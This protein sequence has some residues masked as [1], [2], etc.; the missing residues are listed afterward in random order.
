MPYIPSRERRKEDVAEAID[1]ARDADL[2][3]MAVMNRY[4]VEMAK[5]VT[6]ALPYLPVA[7][8]SL[9]SPYYITSV[10]D[11]DAYVCTYSYLDDAQTAA[12]NAV[13]GR[14]PMLGKLPVTIPG[15]YPYGYRVPEPG[16]PT[17]AVAASVR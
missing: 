2:L 7:I 4:H 14:A 17:P 15:M 13:L 9:A 11:I 6:K 16:E 8:V 1:I 3:V 10:P 5:Q 12:A